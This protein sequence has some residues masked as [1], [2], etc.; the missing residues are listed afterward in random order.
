MQMPGARL[1]NAGGL[2]LQEGLAQAG[3]GG[4]AEAF[5][6]PITPLSICSMVSFSLSVISMPRMM[7]TAVDAARTVYSA[8]VDIPAFQ[9]PLTAY[10]SR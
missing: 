5:Q 2:A 8:P 3:D 7:G 10:C 1:G 4:F 9:S 6:W